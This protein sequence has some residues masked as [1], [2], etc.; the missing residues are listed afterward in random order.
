MEDS[1]SANHDLY[2]IK[3]LVHASKVLTAFSAVGEVLGLRDVVGRTGLNK[4]S[5]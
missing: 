5:P 3:S 2:M 4:K 1:R